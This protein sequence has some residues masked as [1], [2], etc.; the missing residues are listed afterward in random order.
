MNWARA[1]LGEGGAAELECVLAIEDMTQELE[2]GGAGSASAAGPSSSSAA[3]GPSS[4]SAPDPLITSPHNDFANAAADEDDDEA[5][6]ASAAVGPDVEMNAFMTE[7]ALLAAGVSPEQAAHDAPAI[8]VGL[9]P[10]VAGGLSAA[11]AAAVASAAA[12]V[13]DADDAST[14]MEFGMEEDSDGDDEDGDV[15]GDSEE[16]EEGE[17]GAGAEEDA[18]AAAD[19]AAAAARAGG[20]VSASLGAQLIVVRCFAAGCANHAVLVDGGA[21]ALVKVRERTPSRLLLHRS[22]PPPHTRISDGA[23]PSLVPS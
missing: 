9:N 17:E 6:D 18:E 19:A 4:S 22:Q 2:K 23:P 3:A 12:A 1:E 7:T 8:A 11:E 13:A 5:S 16:G 10:A 21:L 14:D 20:G 15:D